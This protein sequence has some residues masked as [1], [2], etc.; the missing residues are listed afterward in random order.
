M[1]RRVKVNVE[2]SY[3]APPAELLA[4][5]VEDLVTA[6]ELA[7]HSYTASCAVCTS[8]KDSISPAEKNP[9]RDAVWH[10]AR[11]LHRTIRRAWLAEHQVP[12]TEEHATWP[13]VRPRWRAVESQEGSHVYHS[14]E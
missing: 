2:P 11:R 6:V 12:R 8:P 9:C 10:V 4:P 3:A 13:L 7:R 5:V 1:A 14:A